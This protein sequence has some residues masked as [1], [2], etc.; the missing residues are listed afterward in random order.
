MTK[1]AV[2]IL[3]LDKV[4]RNMKLLGKEIPDIAGR[5]LKKEGDAIMEESLTQVPVEEGDLIESAKVTG[6]D[7]QGD[8]IVVEDLY[9][10][11]YA[12]RQ[13]EELAWKHQPGK[14]ARYLLD[15]MQ[16]A[17]DGFVDRIG[18]TIQEGISELLG[19]K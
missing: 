17:S 16:D 2:K 10:T 9:D 6:P 8:K 12:H 14:K 15:P 3:G 11:V 7:R 5:G 13:H 19:S 1:I 4:I 18:K